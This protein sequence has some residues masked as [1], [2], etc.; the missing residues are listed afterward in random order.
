MV[1]RTPIICGHCKRDTGM[2]A[3]D[4]TNYV[5]INDIKCPWCQE[6]VI[7]ATYTICSTNTLNDV[8][9]SGFNY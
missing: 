4:F 8:F 3:E 1:T 9:S 5:V 6:I 2:F 7:Y